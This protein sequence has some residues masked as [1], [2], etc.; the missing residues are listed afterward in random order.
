MT[1]KSLVEFYQEQ[2]DKQLGEGMVEV[3]LVEDEDVRQGDIY[4][5]GFFDVYWMEHGASTPI[6][7]EVITYCDA[8]IN[9]DELEAIDLEASLTVN[10]ELVHLQ[11]YEEGRYIE[12]WDGD[13]NDNPNEIEAYAKESEGRFKFTR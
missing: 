9:E 4:V 11:Q 12:V 3:L 2:V 6:Q 10:H 5:Q 7:L 8:D 1:H 13:Y